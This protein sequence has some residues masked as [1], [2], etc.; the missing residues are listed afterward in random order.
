V[1][2]SYIDVHDNENVYLSVDKAEVKVGDEVQPQVHTDVQVHDEE[3]FHF[4]HPAVIGDE[5]W[6]IHCEVKHL[7]ARH[8]IQEICA[9]L[10][11]MAD[12]KKILLPQSPSVAYEELVRMGMPS[13]NGFNESTFRKY[14]SNK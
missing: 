1:Q 7:L 8:G 14:Y 11:K 10:K 4:V 6:Q 13:G 3:L 9:Y 12:E 2:G 5:E